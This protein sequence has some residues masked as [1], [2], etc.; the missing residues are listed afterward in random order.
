[1]SWLKIYLAKDEK[2]RCL[3]ERWAEE[4]GVGKGSEVELEKSGGDS[5]IRLIYPCEV[6]SMEKRLRSL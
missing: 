3:R 6:T 2:P 5:R 1:M 4:Q